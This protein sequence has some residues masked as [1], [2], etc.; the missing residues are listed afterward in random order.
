MCVILNEKSQVRVLSVKIRLDLGISRCHLQVLLERSKLEAPQDLTR[1]LLAWEQGDETALQQL[2]PLVQNELRIQAR[3]YLRKQ[4]GQMQTTELVN[5][6]FVRLL[7]QKRVHWKNRSHFFAISATCMRRALIDY[8]RTEQRQ[9]RGGGIEH[10][11]LSDAPLMSDERSAELLALDEALEVLA[12]QD[13]RKCQTIEM[14]YFGG[15][16]VEEVAECLGVS[17]DT[18]ERDSR[19]ARAW[20]RRELRN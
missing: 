11:A 15:Y 18:V 3:N 19:L 9:K 6:A 12:Q 4:R 2:L 5:E 14:R 8:L 16:T 1:L 17:T 7:N 20:L 10:V 13:K